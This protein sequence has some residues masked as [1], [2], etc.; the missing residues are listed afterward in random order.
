ML[1]NG[2][3][4]IEGNTHKVLSLSF[5]IPKVGYYKSYPLKNNLVLEI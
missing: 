1:L 5:Y 4:E 3:H 2:S